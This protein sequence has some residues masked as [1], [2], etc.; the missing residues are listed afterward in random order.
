M[1]VF[2]QAC[3][4]WV[5]DAG[6]CAPVIA[7]VA[8][9]RADVGVAGVGQVAAVFHADLQ[10]LSHVHVCHVGGRLTHAHALMESTR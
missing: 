5:T 7:A 10:A 3:L 2:V 8:V 6:V 9:L 4:T 1:C